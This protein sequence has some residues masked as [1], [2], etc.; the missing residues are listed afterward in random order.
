VILIDDNSGRFKIGEALAP[1]SRPLLRDLG[2]MDRF[3]DEGHLACYGNVSVWGSSE[4]HCTD[5]VFNPHGHGWHLDR[6]RFDAMLQ[7][8]ARIVG[9]EVLLQGRLMSVEHEHGSWRITVLK[10]DAWRELHANWLIDATGRSSCV[11]RLLGAE[12]I[13]DDRLLA[14]FIRFRS[15]ESAQPDSDSR[16][17]VEAA[18]DGWWY[19]ALVPSGERIVAFFTDSD[20]ADKVALKK[21]SGFMGLLAKTQHVGE[22]INSLGYR[23]DGDPRGVDAGTA[24]LDCFGGPGWFAVG[25]AAVSFDPLSSQGILNALYLGLKAGQAI[26][27]SLAGDPR[28]V[29]EYILR[30]ESIYSA[31]QTNNSTYYSAERRWRERPFWQRRTV[32]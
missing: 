4:T 16:T 11:A 25:D 31:Y 22:L 14:F 9:A 12:R 30:L 20:L 32:P 3:L 5:F 15:Q 6:T 19:T 2:V 8:E 7:D 27:A 23:P 13:H 24:R 21:I 18:P 10:E 1:A 28:S 29:D 26:A 17:F